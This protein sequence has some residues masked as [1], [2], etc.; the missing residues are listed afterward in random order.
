MDEVLLPK[1]QRTAGRLGYPFGVYSRNP[2]NACEEAGTVVCRR[3]GRAG[4]GRRWSSVPKRSEKAL[5]VAV[6]PEMVRARRIHAEVETMG[7][8]SYVG[9]SV[10]SAISNINENLEG[11][12]EICL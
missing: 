8:K 4:S 1:R 5:R 11:T 9:T 12:G 2:V 6:V 10:R 3:T 7:C